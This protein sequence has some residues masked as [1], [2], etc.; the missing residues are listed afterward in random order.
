VITLFIEAKEL[1]YGY[2][3]QRG[4]I[5]IMNKL[6]VSKGIHMDM[7]NKSIRSDDNPTTTNEVVEFV[8]FKAGCRSGSIRDC[9]KDKY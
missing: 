5:I 2:N 4:N 7:D 8:G 9:N 6:E 1:L 3:W